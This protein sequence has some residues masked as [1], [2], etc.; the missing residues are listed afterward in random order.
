MWTISTWPCEAHALE[1]SLGDPDKYY[2]TIDAL[3]AAWQ[4]LA[5]DVA[6]VAS[7]LVRSQQQ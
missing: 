4:I 7:L 6:L 1:F 5:A 3:S 2:V